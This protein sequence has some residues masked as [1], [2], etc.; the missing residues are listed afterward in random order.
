MMKLTIPLIQPVLV[1]SFL[2]MQAAIGAEPAARPNLLIIL[3]DD[4]GWG[5]A[6]F[7]GATDVKTPNLDRLA[8]SGVEF[9]QGYV[10]APQCIPSRAGLVTGRYQQHVGIECNPDDDKNDV[11]QLPEGTA[12]LASKLQADGYRTGMVG[13]W[14]LGE[15]ISSQPFNKGFEWCAYMRHG[16]GY[17]FLKTAWPKDKD[18]RGTN[19]FRDEKDQTIPIEGSGYLTEVFTDKA[20]E[21]IQKKDKRPFFLYLAYH[22]PHWPLEAPEESVAEYRDIVDVNR[23]ICAAMISDMDAQIGRIMDHL[24]SSGRDKTT[25]IVFLSDNGAPQYSGPAITPVKLGENASL[26]GPLYGCKGQLLEGGIRVPFV[27]SWPGTLPAGTTVDWPVISLDLT[28][29]FLAAAGAPPMADTNGLDLLP[30]LKR[31]ISATGPDRALFWRFD[32]QWDLQHAVRR[33]PW[34]LVRSGPKP[35]R[36]LF[37]IS[38]D[39]SEKNDLIAKNPEKAAELAGELDAWMANLPPPN[40]DW[41]TVKKLPATK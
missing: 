7:R 12:T 27:M 40:P 4:Q 19:W 8:A 32:T 20:L 3:S 17:Q 31:G 26:N 23:R 28:P 5:D 6:G 16:M 18:G 14:H 2:L 22:P 36:Q 35:A 15:P 30:Y 11:Y 25:M 34:K 41:I 38:E 33:G 39:P 24:K 29:T 10:S 9:T 1:G 13:K 21:F 37:N